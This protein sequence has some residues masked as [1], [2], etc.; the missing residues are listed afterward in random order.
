MST[1]SKIA[2]PWDTLFENDNDTGILEVLEGELPESS[3]Y[4]LLISIVSAIIWVV[5]I[6]YYNSQV[7][8]LILTAILNR[9]TPWRTH[10]GKQ[11]RIIVLLLQIEI[12]SK[13][14]LHSHN[15]YFVEQVLSAYQFCLER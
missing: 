9:F 8:G 10:L 13:L 1:K 3:I 4:W 2:M 5:Y 7:I 6:T 11:M 14:R 12:R 15:S